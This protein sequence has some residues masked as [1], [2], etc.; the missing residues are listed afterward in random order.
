LL[1]SSL[2]RNS[3]K[4]GDQPTRVIARLNRPFFQGLSW[5]FCADRAEPGG[6]SAV[7]RSAIFGGHADEPMD[8]AMVIDLVLD[9]HFDRRSRAFRPRLGDR[10]APDLRLFFVGQLASEGQVR[11]LGFRQPPRR[12]GRG[13]RRS[14]A[15]VLDRSHPSEVP[16]PMDLTGL[17]ELPAEH[18]WAAHRTVSMTDLRIVLSRPHFRRLRPEGE[19][20]QSP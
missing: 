6:R 1:N 16:A 20:S 19:T 5:W 2:V 7:G 17:A 4:R 8:L 12:R 3:R 13:L 18:R 14:V 9:R 15:G 11:L 10:V